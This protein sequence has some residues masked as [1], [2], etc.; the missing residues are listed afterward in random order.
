[1][2]QVTIGGMYWSEHTLPGQTIN[3]WSIMSGIYGKGSKTI[4]SN[5]GKVEKPVMVSHL[6]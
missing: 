3:Y 2:P 6:R 5:A 1:M 4:K